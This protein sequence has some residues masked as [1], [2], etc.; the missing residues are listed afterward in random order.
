MDLRS[1]ECVLAV[2]ECGHFGRAAGELHLSQ[3]ALSHRIRTLEREI[4]TAL[5]DRNRRGVRL[6]PA[7]EAFLGPARAALSHG[8][9]AVDMA[10]RSAEGLQ[11]RLRLGFTVIASYTRLPQAVQRFRATYP[12]VVV[13]LTETNSPGVEAAL[14]HGEID[15]GVLHPPLERGHLELRRLPAEQLVLALP[16]GHPLTVHESL[17]FADLD[18]VPLLVAPRSVGPVLFDRLIGCFRAAGIEP[19]VV[20]EAT[21]MTTLAGLVA[22]GAGV[23][24]VTRGIASSN[25][26][27]VAFRDVAGAPE[28]PM[29]A[30][31]RSG[32]PT[33]VTRRFLDVLGVSGPYD[34]AR[35]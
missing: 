12:D 26:P 27:G 6:T 3:P 30:A 22:A 7:G 23:G 10:Q 15:V 25:R 28:V 29:A 13:D 33:A 17:E 21:P 19:V 31:W 8:Q 32:G 24:F 11:G 1:V 5:F 20:Q 4:G 14:D 18:G 35:T 34:E 2:A 16:A 9:Q